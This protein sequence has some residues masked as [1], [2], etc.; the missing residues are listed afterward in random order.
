[1]ME[2]DT[3]I[4]NTAVP[5]I[6]EAMR[7]APLD[8]K[9]VLASYTLSLAVF[10][11]VSGWLADRFGTRRVFNGAISLFT[12]SSILCGLATDIDM[13]V[14]CRVL[15]GAG[16]AMLVPVGRLVLARA[17]DKADL[18][19]VMSFVATASL[20]GPMIG[21]VAGGLIVT[22]LD[23]RGV[24][25]VNVPF[26]LLGLYLVGRHLPDTRRPD[27]HPLD[28]VGFVLFGCGLALLSWVLEV[29]GEH[30]LGPV[31][32]AGLLALAAALLAGYAVRA[33]RIAFPLLDA[34]LFRVCTFR[35]AVSGGFLTRLGLG[36][37]QFLFPVLYQV[38]LGCS[39]VVSGLLVLPQALPSF[40][41]KL[42]LPVVL[43]R[44]GYRTVLVG[45]TIL[46]GLM[47]MSFATV[48][49]DTPLWRIGCRPSSSAASRRCSTPA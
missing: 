25:F 15:Q 33:R 43:K 37:I 9:S 34:T 46:V 10:I 44:L 17:F 13:L 23:W 35:A 47:I 32:I 16:G 5:A 12:V 8:V 30:T 29:F 36:G 6:A 39:P 40:G 48:G 20:V 19:K 49:A 2:L 31:A 38:G 22:Y 3:T 1:M 7:V 4:L 24:F 14:A 11:P 45:N 26:G 21:L 27:T 18:V 28:Y 41:L 42:V